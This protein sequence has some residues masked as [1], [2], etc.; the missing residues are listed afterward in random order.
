MSCDLA[1]LLNVQCTSINTLELFGF[2][3]LTSD[4]LRLRPGALHHLMHYKGPAAIAPGVA[5]TGCP[6]TRLET[7]DLTMSVS[8][9]ASILGKVGSQKPQLEF[10]DITIQKWD[11]EILYAISHLFRRIKEVKIKYYRGYPDEVSL[12]FHESSLFFGLISNSRPLS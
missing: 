12:S 6:L 8:Q 7:N 11:T 2:A 5:A 4:D 10:L 1:V 3:E 9:T